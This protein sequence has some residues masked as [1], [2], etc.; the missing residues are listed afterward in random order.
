LL[1]D[2]STFGELELK[3]EYEKNAPIGGNDDVNRDKVAERWISFQLFQ[4]KQPYHCSDRDRI[5]IIHDKTT[6]WKSVWSSPSVGIARIF[7]FD[8]SDHCGIVCTAADKM[9]SSPASGYHGFAGALLL[10]DLKYDNDCA[11][12]VQAASAVWHCRDL[13]SRFILVLS[14]LLQF[15]FMQRHGHHVQRVNNDLT[16]HT[17]QAARLGC[18]DMCIIWSVSVRW[19]YWW[20]LWLDQRRRSAFSSLELSEVALRL[21]A[22]I[23]EIQ[24]HSRKSLSH[25]SHHYITSQAA[26]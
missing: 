2:T 23:K 1:A 7:D 4:V 22:S 3:I 17:G 18:R 8:S 14:S 5:H 25:T 11:R 6:S 26:I 13:S 16:A 9:S 12:P 21:R 20:S 15:S 10:I 19:K 24:H